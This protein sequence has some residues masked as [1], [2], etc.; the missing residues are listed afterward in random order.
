MSETTIYVNGKMIPVK[1]IP[2]I[3][4]GED[5]EEWWRRQIQI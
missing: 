3:G 5:K 2:G 1:T 4:V